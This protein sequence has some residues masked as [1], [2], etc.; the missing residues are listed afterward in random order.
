MGGQITV[1]SQL[2][3]G[4]TF[5]FNIYLP[6]TSNQYSE[7]Q[8][9]H[10]LQPK[11]QNKRILLKDI[12]PSNESI[13]IELLKT[14]GV[15]YAKSDDT[16]AQWDAIITENKMLD[17]SAFSHYNPPI[18]LIS[19]LCHQQSDLPFKH[20]L[21]NP[22]KPL[23]VLQLLKN[24]FDPQYN[25]NIAPV[26][27]PQPISSSPIKKQSLHILLVED[28]LV[29]QK[30]ALLMLQR[31]GYE[32][33]IA[34]NGIEALQALQHHNYEVVF[35]DVQMPEMDGLTA[36][37]HIIETYPPEMRPYIIA[38]TA[39]AMEGDREICLNAGMQDYISKPIHKEDLI[40]ALNKAQLR[41]IAK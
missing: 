30:V 25:A 33:S 22:I 23:K 24:I 41:T 27:I 19:F 39:N 15:V 13:I 35:M 9:L 17:Q 28:N 1:E 40:T 2:D 11:L 32:A 3:R 21:I 8:P 10:H 29:N 12:Y 37:R 18:V 31:L 6:I 26:E 38:M 16:L 5:S 36:T 14:W 7:Y 34:N 4:T 20:C